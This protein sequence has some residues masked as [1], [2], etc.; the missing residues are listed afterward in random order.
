MGIVPILNIDKSFALNNVFQCYT[1][2]V[3]KK[4]NGDFV[5]GLQDA[6]FKLFNILIH[7]RKIVAP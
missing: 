6:N 7:L 5:I 2:C 1:P 4:K 3:V